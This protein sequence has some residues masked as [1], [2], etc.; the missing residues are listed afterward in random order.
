MSFLSQEYWAE[1]E[2]RI[3]FKK[4]ISEIIN[5]KEISAQKW[6][7]CMKLNWM[8]IYFKRLTKNR[9]INQFFN[10]RFNSY[11]SWIWE[12]TQISKL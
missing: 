11:K 8:H 4:L 10:I 6:F 9:N 1:F 12:K 3:I 7:E 2:L 5:S